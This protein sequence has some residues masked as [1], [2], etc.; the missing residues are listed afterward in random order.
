MTSVIRHRVSLVNELELLKGKE[1]KL[2]ADLAL[3]TFQAQILF[4]HIASHK[5]DF[6]KASQG[7]GWRWDDDDDNDIA[8]KSDSSPK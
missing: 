3:K 7:R 8:S 6:E 5:E 1:T 4:D 2:T